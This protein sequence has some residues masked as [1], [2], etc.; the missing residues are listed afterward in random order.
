MVAIPRAS[1]T[2]FC[3]LLLAARA[4]Q[5]QEVRGRVVDEQ[6]KAGVSEVRVTLLGAKGDS[7]SVVSRSDGVF[8]VSA[9]STGYHRIRAERIGY[10]TTTTPWFEMTGENV[11][12]TVLVSAQ[13]IP[14]QPLIV[15]VSATIP[16]HRA[17]MEERRRLG[18]GRFITPEAIA[19]RPGAHLAEHL[20][21]IPGLRIIDTGRDLVPQIRSRARLSVASLAPQ[22]ERENAYLSAA[23]CPVALYVDGVK[24]SRDYDLR[25]GECR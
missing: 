2:M 17:Q 3:V 7:S 8:A 24:W 4:A 12:L 25:G 21:D 20:Q 15:D 1:L 11:S 13:A 23:A 22:H 10:L 14:V 6:S 16:L 5:A 19:R 9:R 18:F